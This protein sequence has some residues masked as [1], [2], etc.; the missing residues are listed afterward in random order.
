VVAPLATG[1]YATSNPETRFAYEHHV[2]P[3]DSTAH[4]AAPFPT[5]CARAVVTAA[6]VVTAT[7]TVTVTHARVVPHRLR[8]R[9]RRSRADADADADAR[10]ASVLVVVVV[11]VVVVVRRAR[12]DDR[13]R[14]PSSG[15]RGDRPVAVRTIETGT[16]R[17]RR[18]RDRS[19]LGERRERGRW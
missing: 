1:A 2:N 9:R 18:A 15:A 16:R 8:S 10:I 5:P 12:V 17:E 7:I 6:A 3:S 11:V 13:G 19:G 14:A 4:V